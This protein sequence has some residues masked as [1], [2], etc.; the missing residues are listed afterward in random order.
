VITLSWR[1]LS[2]T[3]SLKWIIIDVDWILAAIAD[4]DEKTIK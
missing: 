1:D 3:I 2:L 4:G